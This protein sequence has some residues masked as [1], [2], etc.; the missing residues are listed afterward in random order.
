MGGRRLLEWTLDSLALDN[1]PLRDSPCSIRG[2]ETRVVLASV[3]DVLLT[4]VGRWG[5]V[6][7]SPAVAGCP[8][9]QRHMVTGPWHV[10]RVM[11]VKVT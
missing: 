2:E 1:D 4:Q 3:A 11:K 5:A 9:A 8:G 7:G 6:R 10:V